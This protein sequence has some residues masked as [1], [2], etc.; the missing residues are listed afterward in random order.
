MNLKTALIHI[1]RTS[2]PPSFPKLQFTTIPPTP[3]TSTTD[4][5]DTRR[6][7]K[8][9]FCQFGDSAPTSFHAP[10]ANSRPAPGII[11]SPKDMADALNKLIDSILIYLSFR[12]F[13]YRTAKRQIHH[14]RCRRNAI[15]VYNPASDERPPAISD[16]NHRPQKRAK[17]FGRFLRNKIG[18]RA[19]SISKTH[20]V[21]AIAKTPR[22]PS[23]ERLFKQHD[24]SFA[25]NKI[26]ALLRYFTKRRR[27]N[28]VILEHTGDIDVFA[29]DPIINRKMRQGTTNLPRRQLPPDPPPE[30]A[31]SC[32]MKSSFHPIAT[33]L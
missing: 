31:T 15:K 27:D 24:R 20:G 7:P 12:P 23:A 28:H 18:V 16:T 5:S 1:F 9:T 14:R 13:G 11:L 21:V 6:I 19:K 29:H 33:G 30:F 10:H 2:G 8:M 25:A 3:T 26:R 32:L 17:R 4:L 22:R